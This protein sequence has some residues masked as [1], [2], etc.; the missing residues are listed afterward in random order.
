MCSLKL[1][2]PKFRFKISRSGDCHGQE[3]MKNDGGDYWVQ[4]VLAPLLD[5]LGD[6]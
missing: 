6:V 1:L 4:T 2:N 5:L 3:I